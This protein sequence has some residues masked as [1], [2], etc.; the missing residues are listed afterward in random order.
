MATNQWWKGF[1]SQNGNVLKEGNLD[2]WC[3]TLPETNSSHL[4]IDA[5]KMSLTL[6]KA[7]FLGATGMLVSG[8]VS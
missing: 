2:F 6:E 3:D 4:K 7:Y 1:L 8:S 5:W